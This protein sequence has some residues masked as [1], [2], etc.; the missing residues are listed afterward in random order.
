[1]IPDTV[2]NLP[3][4]RDHQSQHFKHSS[5]LVVIL[6]EVGQQLTTATEILGVIAGYLF[7]K[8]TKR[9]DGERKPSKA[10]TSCREIESQSHTQ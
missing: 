2:Y 7:A 1:M 5:M 3:R 6:A 8:T 4:P 9:S 10:V